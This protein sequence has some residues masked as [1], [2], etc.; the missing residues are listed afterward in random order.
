MKLITNRKYGLFLTI[1]FT[2][3]SL[4]D[5]DR[6][7]YVETCFKLSM[8]KYFS[9]ILQENKLDKYDIYMECMMH[10]FTDKSLDI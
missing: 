9:E 4:T 5:V 2:T 10:Q 8:W 3:T 1:Q 7:K 6:G